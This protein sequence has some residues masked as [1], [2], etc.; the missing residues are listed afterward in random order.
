MK[1][2]ILGT[3][4]IFLLLVLNGCAVTDAYN[5]A[6]K[7]NNMSNND[8]KSHNIEAL[9]KECEGADKMAREMGI[10]TRQTVEQCIKQGLKDSGFN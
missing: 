6:V 5:K 7:R 4:V 1:K 8:I 10:E 9:K 2:L 3:L